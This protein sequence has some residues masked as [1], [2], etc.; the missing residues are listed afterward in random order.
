MTIQRRRRIEEI[1]VEE[2]R[3]EGFEVASRDGNWIGFVPAPSDA[4][5][6]P[7]RVAVDLTRIAAAIEARMW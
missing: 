2:F 1:L 5:A 6:F 4:N 7:V 3:C